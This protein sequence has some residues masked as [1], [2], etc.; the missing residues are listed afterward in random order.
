MFARKRDEESFLQIT[1][2]FGYQYSRPI[3]AWE[4]RV[5][6]WHGTVQQS[7]PPDGRHSPSFLTLPVTTSSLKT[8]EKMARSSTYEFS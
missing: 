4:T 5:L 6:S 7:Q 1:V 8:S 3:R 2:L